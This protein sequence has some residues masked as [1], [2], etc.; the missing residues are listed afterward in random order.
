[1]TGANGD[2]VAVINIMDG[3]CGVTIDCLRIGKQRRAAGGYVATG[4]DG[5]VDDDTCSIQID[6]IVCIAGLVLQL[7]KVGSGHVGAGGIILA[8]Y[9]YRGYNQTVGL[10]KYFAVFGEVS[11]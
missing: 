7:V 11:F 1:M 3:S 5:I 2:E 4:E 6:S 10:Y 8:A 9:G